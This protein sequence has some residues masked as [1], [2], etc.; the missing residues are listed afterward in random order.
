MVLTD[1][2]RSH[3]FLQE[4]SRIIG[5][6]LGSPLQSVLSGVNPIV[7]TALQVAIHTANLYYSCRSTLLTNT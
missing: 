7:N 2:A 3:Y 6:V 1:H 4:R 5:D